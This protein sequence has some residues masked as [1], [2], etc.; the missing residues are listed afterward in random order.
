MKFCMALAFNP[1]SEW[2]PLAVAAEEAGFDGLVLSDHLFHPAHLKT[3]YPYTDDG[4]PSWDP[5]TDWP[6]P[7]IA[8]GAL[9]TATHRIR[10]ITAVYLV[11]L[12]HPLLTAK[13]V[14]TADRFSQG[15]VVLGVGTGWMKQE[16]DNLGVPFDRRGARMEEAIHIMR[17]LWDGDF[18]GHHGEF[19]EIE[20]LQMNPTP[21]SP[22]TIW[23]G[24]TSDVALRRAA[25][26]L[27][28]WVGQ[29]QKSSDLRSMIPKLRAWRRDSS[30]ANRSFEIC[31]AIVDAYTLDHY[32]E[33]DELGVTRMT[34]VPW[35]LYGRPQANL[36]EKCESIQRF[37]EEVISRQ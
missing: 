13:L 23:G 32:R 34:T 9:A 8:I 37:G 26:Q 17:G 31:S 29:I 30:L 6:D 33:M 25:Q 14:A 15:R 2:V 20:A 22:I 4:V 3:P 35:L 21:C 19:F 7:L 27:D 16:F 12:R 36:A 5:S 10:F 28:G 11:A 18:S 24:G 1:I